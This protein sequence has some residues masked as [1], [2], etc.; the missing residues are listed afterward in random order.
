VRDRAASS[1]RPRTLLLVWPDP[2]QAAGAGTFLGNLLEEVGAVNV[3]GNRPGWPV[4]SREYLATAPVD[5]LIV[6]DSPESRPVWERAFASGALS[7][8]PVSKAP[9]LRLDEAA[10]TRPGPRVFDMLEKL[11]EAPELR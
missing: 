6:P 1:K 3:A 2:P 5:L 10:L 8:G 11:S 7:L 4:L 9:L